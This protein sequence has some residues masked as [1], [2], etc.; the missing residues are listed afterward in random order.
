M[1]M[2]RFAIASTA[3]VLVACATVRGRPDESLLHYQA[4]LQALASHDFA[5]AVQHLDQADSSSDA[6][7][8]ERAQ[9][10][11]IIAELDPR[12]PGRRLDV[13]AERATRFSAAALPGTWQRITADALVQLAAGVREGN[14]ERQLAQMRLSDA[15][16]MVQALKLQ[17]DSIGSERDA[18]RRRITQ[19]EAS[20]AECDKKLQ[21]K[22]QELDRIRRAI[23]G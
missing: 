3:L 6:M 21:E 9:L 8:A 1:G 23:R 10:L 7:V 11:R 12:N 18:A 2:R 19:L 5:S 22:T 13:A 4:G 20:Q 16:A 15:N 17:I 14:D